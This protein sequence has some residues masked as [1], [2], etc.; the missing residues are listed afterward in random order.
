MGNTAAAKKV[1]AA[2]VGP[3][4]AMTSTFNKDYSLDLEGMK[5]L[6]DHFIDGG[7]KNVI[8]AG[9]T[10]EFYSMTDVERMQVIKTVAEH[11]AGRITV[12][13]CAAH[14]GTQ[15][16][17]ELA[18]QCKDVGCDGVMITPPYYSFSGVE[19]MLKHFELI[20]E[21][22][23]I[24][25]V[26]Y[27]SG[28]VLRFPPVSGMVSEEWACPQAMLDLAAI[29]NVGAFKDASGNYG[30][31][32]DIVRALDGPD[33]EAAVMGSDGMGYHVW[34]HKY[35]SR[36]YLTG[37]GNVW[38]KIE[39]EFFDKLDSGDEK[40][41]MEIVDTYELDYLRTTKATGRYWSCLKF[42]LDE[43]GLPGGVM[44][45]PLLDVTKEDKKNLKAMAKRT[46]LM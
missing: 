45:P 20:S 21:A 7:I 5:V 10:G 22:V 26:G 40:G 8:V 14:S 41:A 12:I 43:L 24:G 38:P 23:D 30:W 15:L 39:V 6:T 29:P 9:S 4:V 27:F 16:A 32:R 35:G 34:G 36:C 31:H 19:G 46:G 13:G 33:G 3:V 2:L 28:S 42:F 25:I 44:R 37:L 18:K 1:K 17:I 11:A